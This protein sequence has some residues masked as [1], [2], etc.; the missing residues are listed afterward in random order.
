MKGGGGGKRKRYGTTC[1]GCCNLVLPLLKERLEDLA[2]PYTGLDYDWARDDIKKLTNKIE[3]LTNKITVLTNDNNQL[4][5]EIKSLRKSD[6]EG[7][8]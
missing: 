3:E 2:D 1:V 8:D 6:Q 7:G 5:D 4:R